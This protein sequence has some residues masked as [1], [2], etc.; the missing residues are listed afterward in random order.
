MKIN[1]N[2]MSEMTKEEKETL[3]A[4]AAIFDKACDN[5]A[6]CD[7]CPLRRIAMVM[8]LMTTAPA[9]FSVCLKPSISPKLQGRQ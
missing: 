3:R 5:V 2:P 4:F 1:L 6:D 9:L 7:N 8:T